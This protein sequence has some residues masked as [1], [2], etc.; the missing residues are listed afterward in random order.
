[1]EISIKKKPQDFYWENIKL[2]IFDV[3]GTLYNQEKMRRLMLCDL[4]LDA[5]KNFDLQKILI[6]KHYR[7]LREIAAIREEESIDIWLIDSTAKV[8]GCSKELV[9]DTVNSWIIKKP[10][11]YL[12]K[13]IFSNVP[14]V[15][16]MIKQ[17]GKK[18][19]ILSDYPAEDKLI[20]M[21][22]KADYIVCSSDENIQKLK[23][24]TKGLIE[25]LSIAKVNPYEAVLVGDRFD[26][27]G[28]VANRAGVW[29]IILSN[30]EILHWRTISNY[31]DFSYNFQKNNDLF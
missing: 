11:K 17:S 1:M 29:P 4:I 15:F 10:I 31:Q 25:L 28:L 27:D 2:V 18:I 7:R 20:K 6:L 26:R 22:L 21:G 13:C 12:P 9:S 24:N 8:I 5:V 16:N 3:D 14:E 19:G 23:P 30:K